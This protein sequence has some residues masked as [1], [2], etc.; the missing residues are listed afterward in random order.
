MKTE[1]SCINSRAIIDY[2]KERNNGDCSALLKNLHTEIDTLPDPEA[3]LR[4]PNNWISCTVITELFER[5]IQILKDEKA[6]YYIAKYAV[7]KT[8]TGSIQSIIVKALWSS[9]KALK[10]APKINDKWNRNKKVEL[11]EIGRNQGS[12]RLH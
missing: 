6:P 8:I 12:I 5:A 10:Q 3:F 4:D 9:K 2:I 11:V 1:T 7:E